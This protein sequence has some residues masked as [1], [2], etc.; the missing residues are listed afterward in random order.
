LHHDNS[1]G[2]LKS[3]NQSANDQIQ[4]F[5]RKDNSITHLGDVGM[6]FGGGGADSQVAKSIIQGQQ[7]NNKL[8]NHD[9][10]TM[11]SS[12]ILKPMHSKLNTVANRYIVNKPSSIDLHSKFKKRVVL[13]DEATE[14]MMEKFSSA[15]NTIPA[16]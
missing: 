10:S 4:A 16:S 15:L 1:L 6:I 12:N 11:A 2:A 9:S 14:D 5:L 3:V 8:R 7:S 13:K